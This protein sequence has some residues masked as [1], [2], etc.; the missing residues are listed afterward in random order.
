[1]TDLDVLGFRNR[2]VLKENE[3]P[4][5]IQLQKSS[6]IHIPVEFLPYV[7]TLMGHVGHIKKKIQDWHLF[8]S[9]CTE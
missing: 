9:L 3:L 6:D 2:N 5:D 1:M 4:L 7:H 8:V